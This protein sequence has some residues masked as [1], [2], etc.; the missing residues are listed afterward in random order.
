M[1]HRLRRRGLPVSVVANEEIRGFW[2]SRD[3]PGSCPHT[4]T[5]LMMVTQLI[6]T[7]RGFP[8]SSILGI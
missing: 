3:L 8:G 4:E 6:S 5:C 2:V 7:G 1:A